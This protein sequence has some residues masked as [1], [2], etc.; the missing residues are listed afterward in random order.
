MY[1]TCPSTGLKNFSGVEKC[2]TVAEAMAWKMSDDTYTVSP[3]EW[4]SLTPLVDE[5]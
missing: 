4:K 3:K 1:Y 5:A 2:K